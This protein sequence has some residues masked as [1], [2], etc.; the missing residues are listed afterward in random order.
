MFCKFFSFCDSHV[1]EVEDS[2]RGFLLYETDELFICRQ[3]SYL[4][5]AMFSTSI[6]LQAWQC[7]T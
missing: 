3:S 7:Q 4:T 6:F 1:E 2:R 5:T